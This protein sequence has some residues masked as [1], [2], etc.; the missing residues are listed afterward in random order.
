MDVTLELLCL[1]FFTSLAAFTVASG[2]S[3]SPAPLL[4]DMCLSGLP[5]PLLA[6]WG[7]DFS[8]SMDKYSE[9]VKLTFQNVTGEHFYVF[10]YF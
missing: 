5:D 2:M 6:G 7:N 8:P 4:S 3:A 10:L 1:A 9:I